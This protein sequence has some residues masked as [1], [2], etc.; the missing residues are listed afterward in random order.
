MERMK[1]NLINLLTGIAFDPTQKINDIPIIGSVEYERQV[2]TWNT[3]A[4]EYPSECLHQLF[5]N[6]V[7]LA[8]DSV[9]LVHGDRTMSYAELDRRSSQVAHGLHCL[10]VQPETIVGICVD[11]SFELM[12]GVLGILEG[13]RGLPAIDPTHPQDRVDFMLRDADARIL[14]TQ[15]FLLPRFLAVE[16]K[17]LS[18]DSNWSDLW[19]SYDIAAPVL[20]RQP[21][22]AYII[23][24][25][26]STGMPKGV[27]VQ[28][29][30]LSNFIAWRQ[31]RFPLDRSDRILFRSPYS[32]D[33]SIP[34]LFWPLIAGARL[35]IV[36]PELRADVEQLIRLVHDFGITVIETLPSVLSMMLDSEHISRCVSLK[37]IMSGGE[38]LPS[39]VAMKC[40]SRLGAELH[41][42]Y[43]PTEATVDALHWQCRSREVANAVPIGR[44][45]LN[46]RVYVLD[47]GLRPVPIGVSRGAL[48]RRSWSCAGLSG[49][50]RADG[51]AVRRRP[52][53]RWRAAVPDRRSGALAGGRR[54]GVPRPGR[55]PGED[56]RLPDR[57]WRDRGRAAEP[58]RGSR[59]RWLWRARMR[60][61]RSGWWRMWLRRM[62][63]ADAARAARRI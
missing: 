36:A 55:P 7:R 2:V 57:A 21:N 51:G 49:P 24:T 42:L 15:R 31:R 22:L 12:V 30:G 11:P 35:I 23:Y 18:L 8:P 19:G 54:A 43:G 34:E 1:D 52:V 33:F 56:A 63:R 13:R 62:Q 10:G 39:D 17:V 37:R 50:A 58:C 44:P 47:E 60:P 27:M 9:A 40:L 38:M 28:H 3:T 41:N 16:A 32:S 61:A 59:M 53:W 48:Y 14:L 20:V 45:I 5:E 46:T 26:G 6:E 4:G 25:S 29:S